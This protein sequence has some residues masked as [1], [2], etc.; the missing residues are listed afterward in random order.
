MDPPLSIKYGHGQMPESDYASVYD[1]LLNINWIFLG[2][3]TL[4][5]YYNPY[6]KNMINYDFEFMPNFRLHLCEK[7]NNTQ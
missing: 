4:A 6:L 5:H 3:L 7:T 2:S 1:R